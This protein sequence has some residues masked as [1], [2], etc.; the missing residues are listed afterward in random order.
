MRYIVLITQLKK[1]N[2]SRSVH[3]TLKITLPHQLSVL[4]V[5]RFYT[6]LANLRIYTIER[7]EFLPG[8]VFFHHDGS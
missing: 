1:K 4:A 8:N 5:L 6:P 3:N 7:Q 2:L